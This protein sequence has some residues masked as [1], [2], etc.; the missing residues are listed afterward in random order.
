MDGHLVNVIGEVLMG[1]DDPQPR[2]FVLHIAVFESIHT[3]R[4][5]LINRMPTPKQFT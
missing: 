4:R 5:S 1:F 2:R 3:I